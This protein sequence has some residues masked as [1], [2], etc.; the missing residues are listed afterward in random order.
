VTVEDVEQRLQAKAEEALPESWKPG[1][2][3]TPFAKLI[4]KVVRYEKGTTSYGDCPI[5]VVES[6]RNQGRYASL[7]IFGT[8]LPNAFKKQQPRRGEV[9]LVEYLGMKHP[10][11]GGQP[12]Q[13]WRVA[14][15]RPEGQDGLDFE[16][17][18]GMTPAPVPQTGAHVTYEPPADWSTGGNADDLAGHNDHVPAGTAFEGADD[19][20]PFLPSIDGIN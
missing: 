10:D 6:L 7:W 20:I 18:F 8:V 2:P 11:G 4:G 13:N 14:V 19:D 16:Q 9:I 15:D 5:V 1:E 3:G 17:A 12:Y